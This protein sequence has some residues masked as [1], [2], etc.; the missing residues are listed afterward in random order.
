MK[1][2]IMD[3]NKVCDDC[4]ECKRCDLNPDKICDNCMACVEMPDQDFAE[5]KISKVIMDE[6]E[7]LP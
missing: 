7:K 3:D 1:I 5:I 2:C 4:G 6:E